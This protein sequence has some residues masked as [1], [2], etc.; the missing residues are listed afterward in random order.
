[1]SKSFGYFLKKRAA[2][3]LQFGGNEY[4]GTAMSLRQRPEPRALL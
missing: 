3:F 4:P 2:S 1:M